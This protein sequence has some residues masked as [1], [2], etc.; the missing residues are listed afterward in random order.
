M[1]EAAL[2]KFMIGWKMLVFEQYKLRSQRKSLDN[3]ESLLLD[4]PDEC[5]VRSNSVTSQPS[6]AQSSSPFQGKGTPI[7]ES[8][9]TDV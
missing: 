6:S 2:K 1:E 9:S 5:H 4:E 7:K 3:M 8:F